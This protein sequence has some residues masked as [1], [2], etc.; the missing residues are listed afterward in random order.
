MSTSTDIQTEE[1]AYEAHGL[2]LNGF[3]AWNAHQAAPR[4]GVLSG[5]RQP[6]CSVIIFWQM[7]SPSPVPFSLVVK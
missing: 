7:A 1:I 5:K 6:P 4:P 2:K 3:V